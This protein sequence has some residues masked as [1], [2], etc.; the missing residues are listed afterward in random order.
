MASRDPLQRMP[1]LGTVEIDADAM[2]LIGRWIESM[3]PSR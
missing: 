3:S 2:S 1:P